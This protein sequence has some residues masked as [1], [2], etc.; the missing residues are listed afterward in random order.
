MPRVDCDTMCVPCASLPPAWTQRLLDLVV[1]TRVA[2][3]S[4][5]AVCPVV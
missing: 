4:M 1:R 3:D 2:C 5:C